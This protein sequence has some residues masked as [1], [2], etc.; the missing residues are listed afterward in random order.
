M[1]LQF[2][3]PSHSMHSFCDLCQSRNGWGQLLFFLIFLIKSNAIIWLEFHQCH[4]WASTCDIPKMLQFNF[5]STTHQTSKHM[6]FFFCCSAQ[7][8]VPPPLPFIRMCMHECLCAHAS[9]VIIVALPW[10][11]V[12]HSCVQH[13]L[14]CSPG[15]HSAL[16]TDVNRVKH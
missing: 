15:P 1:V 12:W 8:P 5:L 16:N 9:E 13:Y 11:S 2:I 4:A 10:L 7:S 3:N 6:E 14:F